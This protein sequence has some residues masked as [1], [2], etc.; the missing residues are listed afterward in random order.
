M[1]RWQTKSDEFGALGHKI[2]H[3]EDSVVRV[4]KYK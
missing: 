1:E 4:A 2:S 3:N